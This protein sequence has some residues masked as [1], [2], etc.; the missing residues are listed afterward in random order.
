MF[1][2][3]AFDLFT[4]TLTALCV[5]AGAVCMCG[6]LISDGNRMAR[7]VQAAIVQVLN[8]NGGLSPE[9]AK[10]YVAEMLS[11]QRYVQDIWS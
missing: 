6:V 7:D 1:V 8:V 10:A 3:W 11:T 5:A 4:Q 2:C 9:K